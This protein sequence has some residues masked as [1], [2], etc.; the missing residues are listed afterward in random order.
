MTANL[1]ESAAIERFPTRREWD[2]ASVELLGDV[3]ARWHLTVESHFDGG[4]AGSVVAV[5]REDDSPAVLKVGFPHVEAIG[6]ALAL[7]AWPAGTAPR[8]FA[9]DPWRWAMLLERI[10]PGEALSAVGAADRDPDRHLAPACDLLARLWAVGSVAGVPALTE[11]VGRYLL[12]ARRRLPGHLPRLDGLGVADLVSASFDDAD[13]LLLSDRGD[14]LVHG[15][16]NPGNILRLGPAQEGRWVAIDPKPMVGDASFDL[17]P[18]VAQL[19][20]PFARRDPAAVVALRLRKAAAITGCD[21]ARAARWAVVR[22][23]LA[24]TWYL[25]DGERQLAATAA[26]ELRVWAGVPGRLR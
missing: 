4:F 19:G 24:L 10:E 18:L 23:A 15:D 20:S 22:A 14:H 21:E 16:F 26:T 11:I 8:V 5:R 6:E 7:G 13:R 1:F 12:D 25:D 9:Q 3:V 2:A 17:A